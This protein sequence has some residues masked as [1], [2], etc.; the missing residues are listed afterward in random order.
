L[1]KNI[2]I[3]KSTTRFPGHKSYERNL[4]DMGGAATTGE[5]VSFLVESRE[6]GG[7]YSASDTSE[8]S[9]VA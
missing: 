3:E 6:N 9:N 4:S 7:R 1:K 8:H 5:S 2:K